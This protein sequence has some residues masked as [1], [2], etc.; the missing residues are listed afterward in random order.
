VVGTSVS[1]GVLVG[2]GVVVVI[3][4]SHTMIFLFPMVN[5]T[6]QDALESRQ[7]MRL[8]TLQSISPRVDGIYSTINN[9]PRVRNMCRANLCRGIFYCFIAF[10]IFKISSR[11]EKDARGSQWLVVWKGHAQ[12]G[13]GKASVRFNQYSNKYGTIP[14]DYRP[15]EAS[16]S[17]R[18]RSEV[19]IYI[20]ATVQAPPLSF[21]RMVV[22]IN[23][24]KY[25]MDVFIP[26]TS[27]GHGHS[28]W[29]VILP[30]NTDI[31]VQHYYDSAEPT[32]GA[33]STVLLS[34]RSGI[35]G[36]YD[37]PWVYK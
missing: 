23:R 8:R 37:T 3:I 6:L 10:V 4:S 1:A 5:I 36:T 24:R 15:L 12:L 11:W 13:I 29:R 26:H 14:I 28:M 19:E 21:H 22:Y 33:N 31:S 34:F 35:P 16:F 27:V 20:D 18:E 9:T 17:N 2:K 30:A 7:A 32:G 25:T